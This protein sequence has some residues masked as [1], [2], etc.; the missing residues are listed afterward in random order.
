[1]G[2]KVKITQGRGA[3]VSR[4][5]EMGEDM[6]SQEAGKKFSREQQGSGEKGR[7]EA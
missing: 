7:E 4:L 6:T 2:K 3:I 1:M 5:P